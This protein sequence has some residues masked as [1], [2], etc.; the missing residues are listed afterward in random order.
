MPVLKR[1]LG[2]SREQ[3]KAGRKAPLV[4]R[5]RASEGGELAVGGKT[6]RVKEG[7]E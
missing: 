1:K 5:W 4:S 2:A 6:E 3:W 7:P